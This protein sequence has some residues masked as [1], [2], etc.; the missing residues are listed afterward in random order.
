MPTAMI[1]NNG[2]INGVNNTP[3]GNT[4]TSPNNTGTFSYGPNWVIL[5]LPYMEQ[6]PL[7]N[8]QATSINNQVSGVGNDANWRALGANVVPYMLCP[9]DPNNGTQANRAGRNWNRG[10]YAANMGPVFPNSG[11]LSGQGYD[12]GNNNSVFGLPA[13]GPFWFTTRPPHRCE[14]IE[15]IQDGSSNTIMMAE[16]RA[17]LIA[18]DPR[19]VWAL[20]H[21]GSSSVAGYAQ[22]DCVLINARNSGADDVESCQDNAAQGMGCWASCPSNQAAFRSLHTGGVNVAMGDGTVRFLRDSISQRALYQL[23]SSTDNNPLPNDAQ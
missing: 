22:G 17:G 15:S 20:G 9:S 8:L 4:A 13:R 7:F 6:A 16:V 12:G 11:A 5:C 10:N 21:V 2:N 14:K 23:G 19:G 18:T 1:I 3:A